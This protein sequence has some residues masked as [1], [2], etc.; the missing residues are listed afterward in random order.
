MGTAASETTTTTVPGDANKRT[1]YP[2]MLL[3]S[4]H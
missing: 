2:I 4:L 1:A 3:F